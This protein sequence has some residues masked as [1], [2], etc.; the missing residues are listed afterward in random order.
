MPSEI[1]D[2]IYYLANIS[3]L[4]PG[5]FSI[6]VIIKS[7]FLIFNIYGVSGGVLMDDPKVSTLSPSAFIE[8][9]G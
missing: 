1:K 4:F 8:I 9:S 5:N 6:F 3:G 2:N 7:N